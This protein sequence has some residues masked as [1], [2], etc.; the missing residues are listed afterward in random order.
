MRRRPLGVLKKPP[1]FVPEAHR[2]EVMKL[3]KAALADMAWDY[4]LQLAQAEPT[5]QVVEVTE[6]G[7]DATMAEFRARRDIILHYRKK[8]QMSL[9]FPTKQEDQ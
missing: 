8:G 9:R 1:L 4:A 6:G 5:G 2:R 7:D 3:S